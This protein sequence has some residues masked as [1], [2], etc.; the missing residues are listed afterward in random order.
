LFAIE[1]PFPTWAEVC[2]WSPDRLKP[3]DAPLLP[4]VHNVLHGG[5]Y[6]GR[7]THYRIGHAVA[8]NIWGPWQRLPA[9]LDG[10][11]EKRGHGS[12]FVVRHEGKYW[13]FGPTSG[14]GIYTS[15]DLMNWEEVLEGTKWFGEGGAGF[16]PCHRDPCLLR[17]DDGTYFQYYAGS[18]PRNRNVVHVATSRD[19]IHW[20]GREPCYVHELP[21]VSAGFG[22]FESPFV[23]RRGRLFY[24]FVGFSH[25]HYYESFVAVSDDPYHFRQEHIITT[26]FSHAPEIIEINGESF[27]S[28]CGIEDPQLFNRSGLWLARLAWLRPG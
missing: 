4:A 6:C 25:R 9:A 20:Q 28:S 10:R 22:A 24:L 18:D 26:V 1:N 12:P 11:A 2:E 17:L 14:S 3:S 7:P 8:D 27:L 15:S 19:L 5:L 21:G 16:A 23:C 13:L